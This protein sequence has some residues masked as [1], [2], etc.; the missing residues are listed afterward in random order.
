ME[1]K[2]TV[3]T[4]TT[5]GGLMGS[6]NMNI[7]LISL[8]AILNGLGIQPFAPGEFIVLL[9]ILMGYSIVLASVLVTFGRVSDM[10]G[11]TRL[12]TMGFIIFTT[13]SILLSIIPDGSGNAGA[14][15]L[16]G[17]RLFQATGSGFLMV[18]SAALITDAFP[19]NERGKALGINGIAFTAGTLIGLI[20][21]GILAASNWHLVFVISVPFGLAGTLWSVYRLKPT[22][23]RTAVPLDYTGNITLSL[24]LILMA[25]GFTYTLVPYGDSQMGW[26]NPWVLLSFALGAALVIT[27]IFAERRSDHPLFNLKLF[28]VKAFSYGNMSLFLSSFG[29]G[30]VTFLVV[31][32]LQ[33]I[34]LPL[35]GYSYKDTP[36]WAGIYMLPMMA[37]IVVFGPLGGWLT[38]R[39]GARPFATA[40]MAIIAVS[41][42]MLTL[43]PYDFNVWEFEGILVLNGI[44]NGLFISPNTAGI[45]N[46]LPARDRGAGYGISTTLMNIGQT[47][48]MAVFFSLALTVFSQDLP[49]AMLSRTTAIGVPAMAAGALSKI[50]PS[51]ALFASLLGV[52]PLADLPKALV[53]T[54]PAGT[55]HSLMASGFFPSVI[56]PSFIDGVRNAFYVATALCV[57][58]ALFSAMRGGKFIHAEAHETFAPADAASRGGKR[59]LAAERPA[60]DCPDE[61]PPAAGGPLSDERLPA[62]AGG[63][64]SEKADGPPGE[65][66]PDP[67]GG[68]KP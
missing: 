44:G 36:L 19:A 33:G 21:G 28:R 38:D 68:A 42:F 55:L 39:F 34:Y 22:G 13:A 41:M 29:R 50:P 49:G 6:I 32:W 11:R 7:V 48:S 16:I 1:Y 46:S 23:Q 17:L 14:Y 35:H 10:Y 45:M 66:A 26:T 52:N 56:G 47:I 18:N 64:P 37:G 51:G 62:A 12:Y 63:L 2:W 8:P 65:C 27:F 59:P 20:I 31:I 5:L 43:L 3:L 67:G 57:I 15:A 25:L 24:G 53:A 9:W 54:I 60:L 30:A 4:N 40:G 58:G 61:R